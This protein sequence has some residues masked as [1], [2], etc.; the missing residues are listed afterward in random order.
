MIA[1]RFPSLLQLSDDERL[2]LANELYE[3]VFQFGPGV[4]DEEIKARLDES[5]RQYEGDP[6]SAVSWEV[7][8]ARLMFE[9]VWT[10]TRG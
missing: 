9:D 5:A 3:S 10:I 8:K 7:L 2:Q 4:S 1:E 6:D